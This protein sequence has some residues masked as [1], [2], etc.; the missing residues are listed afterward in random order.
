[1][2]VNELRRPE[3]GRH[4][5]STSAYKVWAAFQLFDQA[6][7]YSIWYKTLEL[8]GQIKDGDINLDSSI[9]D[10]IKSMG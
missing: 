7:K 8:I 2:F 4:Q 3:E 6:F 5:D 9:S 1:M 10:G